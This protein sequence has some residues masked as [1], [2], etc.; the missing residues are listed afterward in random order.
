MTR[1]GWL[2]IKP[3][4]MS[5]I[6]FGIVTIVMTIVLSQLEEQT[7]TIPQFICHQKNGTY[8]FSE[9]QSMWNNP[10]TIDMSHKCILPNGSHLNYTE[11]LLKHWYSM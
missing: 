1:K 11:E 8:Q 6:V 10:C 5:L 7:E 3:L 9:C 2:N 4:A